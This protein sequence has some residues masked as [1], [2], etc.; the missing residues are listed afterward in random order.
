MAEDY[1]PYSGAY[2]GAQIDSILA[3]ANASESYTTAEKAKLSNL[4]NYDDTLVKSDI[5]D[6]KSDKVDKVNGKGLSTNDYT[7]AEKTKLSGIEAEANKTVVDSSLSSTSTNPVRNSTV[8]IALDTKVNKVNGK[9]LSTNDYT[10]AE[11]NKLASLENYDDSEVRSLIA[12]KVDKVSGKSLS[13]ND[14]TTAEK[15][16]LASLS[17]YDDTEVR[18]LISNKV[19]KVSGKG[20]STNDYTTADKAAVDDWKNGYIY[21]MTSNPDKTIT[22][23]TSSAYLVIITSGSDANMYFFNS[24]STTAYSKTLIEQLTGMTITIDG[25]TVTFSSETINLFTIFAR[26]LN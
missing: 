26:K 13:T 25:L 20:L 19:D 9:G 14:Y 5:S 16:K 12:G 21:R 18:S 24:T 23:D 8:K 11:K 1:T 7:T 10:T 4:F 6:L 17:N 3:K 22:L 15:T 2:T